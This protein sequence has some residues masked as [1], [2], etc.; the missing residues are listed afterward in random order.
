MRQGTL[1]Y[2]KGTVWV[3]DKGRWGTRKG[4][5]GHEIDAVRV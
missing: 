3:R 4:L 1:G 5:L 2:E